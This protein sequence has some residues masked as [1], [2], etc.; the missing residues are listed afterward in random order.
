[1]STETVASSPAVTVSPGHGALT[2]LGI[3]SVRITGGFWAQRQE[4]NARTTLKHCL[5]WMERLGWIANFDRTA[6]GEGGE[7]AGREFSDSEIYKLLEALAWESARSRDAWAEETFTGLARRVIAAQQPDGYLHTK[8]GGTGQ[9]SRYS[10]LEWGHELYCAGHFLQAAVA[11][12]RT[13]GAD[14]L[15][16]AAVS[17]ADHI[18]DTFGPDGRQAVCGHPEIEPAWS[19]CTGSPASAGISTRLPCS[20]SAVAMARSRPRP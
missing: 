12:A 1:M 2:P 18:C 4:V 10:D 8:F 20:S 14:D 9:P 19:S 11:R 13:A 5:D 15:V 16:A 17:L 6:A 7:R 3:D